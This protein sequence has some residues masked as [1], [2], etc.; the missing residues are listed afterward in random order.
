M[1]F[2]LQKYA[3]HRI[4]TQLL[5]KRSKSLIK[6]ENPTSTI[7]T[8]PKRITLEDMK[9]YIT[10]MSSLPIGIEKSN[11]EVYK[12]NFIRRKVTIISSKNIE[13][14]LQLATNLIEEIK[15]IKDTELFVLDAE[16]VFK[17]SKKDLEKEYTKLVIRLNQ[18]NNK[19]V[20]C[21]ILGLDKFINSLDMQDIEFQEMLQKSYS[22]PNACL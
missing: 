19:S 2:K 12:Y 3:S 21:V 20:V 18:N 1:N 14:S 10:D 7:P 8:I 22:N 6:G 15:L 16:N 13:D 9:K 17:T 4:G 5:K 11:L